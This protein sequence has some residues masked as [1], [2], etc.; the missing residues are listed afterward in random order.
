MD[1]LE[2]LNAEG[3]LRDQIDLT[4]TAGRWALV[5][6][7][8]W[9]GCRLPARCG[10]SRVS[11]SPEPCWICTIL[12]RSRSSLSRHKGPAPKASATPISNSTSTPGVTSGV[13]RGDS[14]CDRLEEPGSCFGNSPTFAVSA[15]SACLPTGTNTTSKD[16]DT[17][18]T[19]FE[20]K[21]SECASKNVDQSKCD[22]IARWL[23]STA[24]AFLDGHVRQDELAE[25]WLKSNNVVTASRGVAQ[26][27][28]K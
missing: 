7:G 27:L 5:G 16:A 13:R 25:K 8:R 1:E 20:L 19:L 3:A 26:W 10:I 21:T 15:L 22:E 2:R 18:H 12:G 6:L 28:R 14:T 17:F 24:L 4:R 9:V 11:I 23:T